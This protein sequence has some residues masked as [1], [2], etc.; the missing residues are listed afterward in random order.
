MFM[1]SCDFCIFSSISLISSSN[2]FLFSSLFSILEFK[3]F[4][5]DVIVSISFWLVNPRFCVLSIFSV[6]SSIR[7]FNSSFNIFIFSNFP[8][9]KLQLEVI[10]SISCFKDSK[11]N[12]YFS[13][14]CKKS[15]TSIFL[16]SDFKSTYFFALL[17]CCFK[18]SKLF[19]ISTKISFIL[20]TLSL[21]CSNFFSA[22]SFLDLNLT[23]PAASSNT[24]LLSSDLLLKISSIFLGQL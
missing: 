17:A 20:K 9:S 16:S 14:L 13:I 5:L 23:I 1:S 24:F 3:T 21:V 4:I 10:T 18:G 22:S 2:L 11:S 19:S 6:S 7:S 12:L 15:P 8:S